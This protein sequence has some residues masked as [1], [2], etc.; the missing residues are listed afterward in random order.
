MAHLRGE[1]QRLIRGKMGKWTQTEL[2]FVGGLESG[3]QREIPFARGSQQ[4][5]I[6]AIAT[7]S[8]K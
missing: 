2:C 5:Y 4:E 6:G 3:S 8:W 1:R 7:Q